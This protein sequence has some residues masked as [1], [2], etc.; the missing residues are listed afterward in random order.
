MRSPFASYLDDAKAM[1]MGIFRLTRSLCLVIAIAAPV[2]AAEVAVHDLVR[3]PSV[4][5]GKEVT[6]SGTVSALVTKTSHRGNV[7]TTFKLSDG[8][9]A[10]TV[11]SWGR[12]SVHDGD[13]VEVRGI[14][15]QV[16]QV[17]PYTF[18]NEI[19]A[20]SVRATVTKGMRQHQSTSAMSPPA[21]NRVT[22]NVSAR[23]PSCTVQLQLKVAGYDPGPMDCRWGL[24]TSQ[25]R[26]AF[27]RDAGLSPTGTPDA[28][29]T[30]ALRGGRAVLACHKAGAPVTSC[31]A[32][33]AS[34]RPRRSTSRP[35]TPRPR[36]ARQFVHAKCSAAY[37]ACVANCQGPI[38]DYEEGE[39]RHNTD[40]EDNCEDACNTGG[41]NCDDEDDADA[42]CDEFQI[43]C[44]NECP[45][46]A[47]DYN[48]GEYLEESDAEDL[49]EDACSAGYSACG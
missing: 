36:P 42:R 17:G 25:A 20:S 43:S 18:H 5:D 32:V 29:T 34:A 2:W 44:N 9:D 3:N 19:Q 7:Y 31:V 12:L 26:A 41:D 23:A 37:N 22:S 11:F 40:F 8:G 27:Q 15:Q 35:R 39:Y 48:K 30:L 13:R 24:R 1:V 4:F 47:Y 45:S 6:L 38:F 21:T 33:S 16:K 10:V 14:F 28:L 49:C 46:D